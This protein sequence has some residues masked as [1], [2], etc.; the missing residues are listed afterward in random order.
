MD[1][2]FLPV[3]PGQSDSRPARPRVTSTALTLHK[4]QGCFDSGGPGNCPNTPIHPG[5][6]TLEYLMPMHSLLRLSVTTHTD[7]KLGETR[8]L[9]TRYA[10]KHTATCT[11]RLRSPRSSQQSHDQTMPVSLS[12]SR[13]VKRRAAEAPNWRPAN[14]SDSKLIPRWFYAIVLVC[15]TREFFPLQTASPQ[16]FLQPQAPLTTTHPSLHTKMQILQLLQK[17]K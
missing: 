3:A 6:D 10:P 14:T 17:N 16:C 9:H 13:F 2:G 11:R 12:I 1:L 8:W 5:C 7:E 4:T 15:T